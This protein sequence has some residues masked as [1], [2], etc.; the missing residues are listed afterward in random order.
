MRHNSRIKLLYFLIIV[1]YGCGRQ[2]WQ[3]E[4]F[5]ISEGR[6]AVINSVLNTDSFMYLNHRLDSGSYHFK[7]VDSSIYRS[8]G[9]FINKIPHKEVLCRFSNGFDELFFSITITPDDGSQ[10]ISVFSK[11][12]SIVSKEPPLMMTDSIDINGVQ[13]TNYM[14]LQPELTSKEALL[15]LKSGKIVLLGEDGAVLIS[16]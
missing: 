7:E 11:D 16:M 9:W 12:F 6:R 8:N 14:L 1:L 15:F 3:L 2:E 13:F 4:D 10:V 5:A